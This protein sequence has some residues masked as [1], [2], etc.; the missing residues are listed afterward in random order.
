MLL[1]PFRWLPILMCLLCSSC[2]SLGLL[3]VNIPASFGDYSRHRDI[4]YGED[5]RNKLDIYL[6]ARAH[7]APVIVFIHGGGWNNGDKAQYKFAGAALAKEGWIA[8]LPNYRLYPAVKSP[9]F[10]EDGARAVAW[11]RAHA[12]EY[13]GNPD[14]LY[15]MGH[16]AGAQIAMMLALDSEYLA[17]V[18]GSPA[19]L[20][21]V[22]GLAGPYDF[23]PFTRGYMNDLFGPPQ[24]FAASQPINYVTANAPPTLLVHGLKDTTVYPKNT[25]NLEAALVAAGARTTAKYYANAAHSDL[26]A[27]LSPLARRRAGTLADIREFINASR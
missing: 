27:A 21:G 16:S 1:K 10:I 18:G 8:V 11:A 14:R 15:L 6:P 17:A 25:I 5:Q 22:I 9:A 20:H 23:L 26:I 12:R 7:D 24:R 19:W 3:A 4:A 13:G 2:G